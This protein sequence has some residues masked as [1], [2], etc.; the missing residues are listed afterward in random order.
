[1]RGKGFGAFEQVT[2]TFIDSVKGK[3]VLGTFTTDAKGHLSNTQVTIPA[4]STV[5]PQT[6]TAAGA[7]SHQKA[8]AKFTVT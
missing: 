6:I 8:K 3:T 4:N 7:G 5:G 2:I 1:V